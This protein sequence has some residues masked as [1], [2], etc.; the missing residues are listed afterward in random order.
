MFLK[1]LFLKCDS[2]LVEILPDQSWAPS[3]ARIVFETRSGLLRLL[4]GSRA[5]CLAM[6]PGTIEADPLVSRARGREC[7]GLPS[8]RKGSSSQLLDYTYVGSL[9]YLTHMPHI[10]LITLT[11]NRTFPLCAGRSAPRHPI[12]TPPIAPAMASMAI[13]G[14]RWVRE[15]ARRRGTAN[16]G[17][18][19]SGI[20]TWRRPPRRSTYAVKA[21]SFR[22]SQRSRRWG[23]YLYSTA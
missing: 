5:Q 11:R 14:W 8:T 6:L 16:S 2:M 23:R 20:T 18:T 4:P 10:P 21:G 12:A 13:R 17:I 7:V 22:Q 15:P 9:L 3:R 19:T 1:R